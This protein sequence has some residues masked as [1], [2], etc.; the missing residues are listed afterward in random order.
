MPAGI[1]FVICT[2]NGASKLRPT[3]EHLSAQRFRQGVLREVLLIDNGS[4][5][6]TCDVA[7][8]CLTLDRNLPLRIVSERVRGTGFARRRGLREAGYDYVTF[9]DDDNWLVPDFGQI[10][11]DLMESDASIGLV[12]AHSEG[13]FAVAKP[14]WFDEFSR[15]FAVGRQ[16]SHEGDVT[17]DVADWWTAGLTLRKAAWEDLLDHGFKPCIH[18][19]DGRSLG[20]GEDTEM[21]LAILLAGWRA[22]FDSRL[23]FHHWMPAERL[24]WSYV[25]RLA[26]Q[27][28]EPIAPI[29]AY[30][31]VLSERQRKGREKEP[32]TRWAVSL[33]RLAARA[34]LKAPSIPARVLSGQLSARRAF[35]VSLCHLGTIAATLKFRSRYDALVEELR[36]AT[37]LGGGPER[38]ARRA[39][40]DGDA[41]PRA[42][43]GE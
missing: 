21:C 9:V 38:A 35:L 25:C 23:L 39:S 33:F 27:A 41:I 12:C 11:F 42:A 6:D 22:H 43:R 26:Y 3:L 34:V 29:L 37:W 10:A 30:R 2:H 17:R 32:S 16:F 31:L 18:G 40:E 4:T 8:D 20:A 24:T 28:Q 5:D 1:S 15:S 14:A 13:V 19:R 36:S 7:R